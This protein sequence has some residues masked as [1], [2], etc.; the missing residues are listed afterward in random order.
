MSCSSSWVIRLLLSRCQRFAEPAEQRAP[1]APALA[2]LSTPSRK[3]T[4]FGQEQ[5]HPAAVAGQLHRLSAR[6]TCGPLLGGQGVGEDD[7]LAGHDVEEQRI[8]AHRRAA[9]GPEA[10]PLEAADV[11][12]QC[13]FLDLPTVALREPATLGPGVRERREDARQRRRVGPARRRRCGARPGPPSA[14]LVLARGR[15][16]LLG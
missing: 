4:W 13:E 8:A 14:L 3:A 1:A 11:E 5:P 10:P 12:V 6:P 9:D 15:L 7:P 16:L 2:A